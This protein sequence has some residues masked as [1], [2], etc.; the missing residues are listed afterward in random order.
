MSSDLKKLIEKLIEE[1]NQHDHAYYVLGKPTI[2]DNAYDQ[3]FKKLEKLE[4]ENPELIQ[5][6]S[7]TQRIGEKPRDGF[8]SFEHKNP[9]LSLD[10]IFE[11]EEVENFIDRI[12][13]ETEVKKPYF[14]VEPKFDGLSVNVIYKKGE[15]FKAGTRGNGMVGEDVTHNVKTIK[16]LPLKLKGNNIPDE[17]HLRA[18]VLIPIDRFSELNKS[19]IEKGETPFANPRNAASGALRQLDPKLSSTRPL[20]IFFFDLNYSENFE[21]KSHFEML[22]MLSDFGLKT[23]PLKERVDS[24][25][26]IKKFHHQLFSSRDELN[27]EIDGVVVKLDDFKL[28]E[29]MGHRARSPRW[30]FAYKFESRKEVTILE[31]I[32]VQVG[33]QGTLTPVAVLRPVDVGGVTVSR[34]SLHNMDIIEKLDVRIGD[35]VKVARAGDVIPEVVEVNHTQR[36]KKS[37]KFEMISSCPVCNTEVIREGA[38]YFCPNKASCPA[39]LKWSIIHY[40]SK[41]ALDIE[42][43]GK[44]TCDLLVEKEMVNTL[45]DLYHLTKEDLL[46]LEGFKDKK[47]ENLLKAINGSKKKTLSQFLFAL[48]IRNVGEEVAKLLVKNFPS[49]EKLSKASIEQIEEIK[50]IGPQIALTVFDYFKE[51]KNLK[52]VNELIELGMPSFEEIDQNPNAGKLKNQTFVLTGE[53]SSMPRSV[54]KKKIETLGGKVTSSVSKKTSFVV[55]GEN[56][57]S[58]YEKAQKLQVEI[59]SEDGFLKL[60]EF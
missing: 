42:G 43:L 29:I 2:S 46:S 36:S 31:D 18:E 25:E 37:K 13:K 16:S 48:G 57:G 45:V 7:P 51:G 50:G 47:A 20:D 3:L 34:A 15:F 6:H 59:L 49:I 30:A 21:V 5:A 52:M 44:E 39:Q 40:G 10:S 33:R 56:P 4:E 60:V 11:V 28:R 54:A 8:E 41:R 32:V 12:I 17:I 58:K 1:I 53:L 55:V 35:E 9:L 22:K 14:T 38:F 23:P 19:I 27:F 24:I 26:G